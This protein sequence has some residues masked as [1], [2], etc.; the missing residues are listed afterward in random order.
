M[1]IGEFIIEEV[2][3]GEELAIDC[4]FNVEGNPVILFIMQHRF[5]S[6][7]DVGDLIYFTSKRVIEDYREK[8]LP[9]LN[10]LGKKANLK[11]YTAHV[12]VSI[13]ESVRKINSLTFQQSL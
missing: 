11:N 1:D 9:F 5:A 13:D 6:N 4:Y 3:E 8:V 12:E 7:G 10:F 2:L